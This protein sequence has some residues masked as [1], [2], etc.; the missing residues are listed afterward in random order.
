[1]MKKLLVQ[2]LLILLLAPQPAALHAGSRPDFRPAG[3]IIA[4]LTPDEVPAGPSTASSA[5]EEVHSGESV[6]KEEAA[7]RE[8]LP[9]YLGGNGFLP[10]GRS[11][12]DREKFWAAPSDTGPGQGEKTNGSTWNEFYY[13]NFRLSLSTMPGEDDHL[14]RLTPWETPETRRWERFQSLP[15]QLRS[16]SYRETIEG[17]GVI[18]EPRIRLGIEF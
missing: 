6:R 16:G 13:G 1:M 7:V 4:G 17:V 12:R 5:G 3:F 15:G 9:R 2:V 10:F 14:K 11:W 18:V 8:E